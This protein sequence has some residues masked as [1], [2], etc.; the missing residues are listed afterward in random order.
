MAA[1]LTSVNFEWFE[2]WAW[3]SLTLGYA[4]YTTHISV[5]LENIATPD[6]PPL[7]PHPPK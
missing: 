4:T 3:D 5:F 7:L 2:S 1:S 6:P